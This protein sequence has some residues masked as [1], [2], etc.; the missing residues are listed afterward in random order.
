MSKT[1]KSEDMKMKKSLGYILILI[2]LGLAVATVA[3]AFANLQADP[4]LLGEDTVAQE[5]IV[6]M[7]D[8]FCAGDYATAQSV[9]QGETD[10]GVDRQPADRVGQIIWEAFQSSMTYELVGERYA[11]NSGI[12][13]DIVITTM[14]VD[15]VIDY[16]EAN[17]KTVLEQRV[18]EHLGSQSGLDEIY[19][20]ENQYRDEF[21][22]SVV[23]DVTRAAV[24][25]NT[26]TVQT[27]LTLNLVWEDDQW[28]VVP[29]EA[30]LDAVSGGILG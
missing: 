19:D 5:R 10:L 4:D 15:A 24:E 14:D 28:W 2:G 18:N 8:A 22:M 30:L 23:Q 25:N 11:T 13:Q 3:V 7:M 17:A 21:V 26:A 29:N 12:A 16:V 1:E 20:E 6:T 9:L 27:K